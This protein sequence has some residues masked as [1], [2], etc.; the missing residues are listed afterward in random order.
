VLEELTHAESCLGSRDEVL[1]CP[2]PIVEKVAIVSHC[3][4]PRACAG[5]F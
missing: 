2:Y 5:M 3:V 1:N 4:K